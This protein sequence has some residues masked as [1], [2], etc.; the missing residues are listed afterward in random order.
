MAL[1]Y[2]DILRAAATKASR[3]GPDAQRTTI[4][5]MFAGSISL[6]LI[7]R[8]GGYGYVAVDMGR[9]SM[10][11]FGRLHIHEEGVVKDYF[12]IGVTAA[13]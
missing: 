12:D 5:D 10:E 8:R 13:Y 3:L 1:K 11:S 4:I 6:G 2:L 9:Q 7:A